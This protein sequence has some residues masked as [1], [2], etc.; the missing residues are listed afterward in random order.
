MLE[1]PASE[2]TS[3]CDPEGV[4]FD[5]LLV[6]Q[7]EHR[8][9]ARRNQAHE[10]QRRAKADEM[11]REGRAVANEWA[12]ARGHADFDAYMLAERIDHSEAC[13]RV[14]LSILAGRRMPG[15]AASAF[16]PS[17][18]ARALGVT[19]REFNPSAEQMAAG[20]RALGLEPTPAAAA[21]ATGE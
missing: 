17:D 10:R 15:G 20:R 4:W 2:R 9:R 16:N 6:A 19:A 21:A 7:A 11:Q 14:A 12:R 1:V 5:E 13:R 18:A 8:C 3:P